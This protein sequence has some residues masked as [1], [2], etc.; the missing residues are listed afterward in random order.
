MIT[1]CVDGLAIVVGSCLGTSPLTVFAES[2]VGI[3]EGGRTGL[4]ALVVAVGFGISMFLSPIFASIPPYATGPAIVFV[5][6]LMMEHA[7]HVEWEDVRKAVPAFLTILLMPLTYSVAY[8]VIAGI[9]ASIAIW[10][11]CFL[12]DIGSSIIFKTKTLRHV[13]LD[14]MSPFFVAFGNEQILIDELPGYKPSGVSS[15]E[16]R[17]PSIPGSNDV[18]KPEDK[19]AIV[20]AEDLQLAVAA[21]KV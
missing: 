21:Y 8:G 10:L 11:F 3:R 18:L 14:S 19:A 1:M 12:L 5:G 20:S 15:L 17:H 4:T 7:A 9:M 13:W 6:A 16:P 2:S